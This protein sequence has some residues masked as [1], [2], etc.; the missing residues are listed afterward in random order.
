LFTKEGIILLLT[1]CPAHFA[2]YHEIEHIYMV[3]VYIKTGIADDPGLP[4]H[5][6][7][8]GGELP[9]SRSDPHALYAVLEEAMILMR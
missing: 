8:I 1:F 6:G 3:A 7:L 2:I 4:A 5:R 9:I